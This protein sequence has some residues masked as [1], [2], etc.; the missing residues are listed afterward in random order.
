VPV[1]LP[2]RKP[3]VRLGEWSGPWLLT[4]VTSLAGAAVAAVL[5]RALPPP[6]VLP[7]ICVLALAAAIA[8]AGIACLSIRRSRT[9]GITH[10]DLAGALTI[11]SIFAALL[12]EPELAL[13][14]LESPPTE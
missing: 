5:A 1:R 2:G 12:S 11:V 4:V 7:A 9:A 6:L 3:Q 13:P 10:W 8:V 14:L